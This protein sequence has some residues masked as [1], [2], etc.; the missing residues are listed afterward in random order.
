MPRFGKSMGRRAM[1]GGLP[2]IMPTFGG[3]GEKQI[4]ILDL[5]MDISLTNDDIEHIKQGTPIRSGRLINSYSISNGDIVS[6]AP[7]VG[8]V[9]QRHNMISDAVRSIGYDVMERVKSQLSNQKP[10]NIKVPIGSIN[11]KL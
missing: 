5:V 11:I 2:S 10:M 9:E 4:E 8:V 7:Y 3:A 6:S 1:G